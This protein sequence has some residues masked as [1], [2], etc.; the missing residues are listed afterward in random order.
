MSVTRPLKFT[1]DGQ[2]GPGGLSQSER[3]QLQK[4]NGPRR[5]DLGN[6]GKP[7]QKFTRTRLHVAPRS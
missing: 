6:Q 1:E 2:Q 4:E 3:D 5:F 7:G